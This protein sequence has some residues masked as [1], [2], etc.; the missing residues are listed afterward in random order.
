MTYRP[1]KPRA[2][3]STK[4]IV[5]QLI[6]AAG[7]AEQAAFLL[8]RGVSQTYAYADP[9]CP[10]AN[11][12]LDQARRLA[13]ATKSPAL[14][15]ALAL[16]M[17]GCYLPSAR[18]DKT[19]NELMARAEKARADIVAIHLRGLDADV[20]PDPTAMLR[21]IDEALSTLAQLRVGVVA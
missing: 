17:G 16:D 1:N 19:V 10:D 20:A 9:A 4:Q 6:E 3:G 7:G 15:E 2:Y 13:A 12:T 11:I 21:L 14:A 18:S 8:G 5:G